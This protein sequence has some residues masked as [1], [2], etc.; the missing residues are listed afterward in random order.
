MNRSARDADAVPAHG[1]MFHHFRGGVHPPGQGAIT[2]DDLADIIDWIGE[3]RFLSAADWLERAMAGRLTPTDRCLT[4]DDGLRCQYD[5]ALPVLQ[6]YGLTAFWFTYTSVLDGVVERLELYR[7]FRSVNFPSV[8]AF[9]ETFFATLAASPLAVEVAGALADFRS[10][11]YLSQYVFYT[12][13]DRWFRFVRDMVLGPERYFAVMDTLVQA[14]GLD[15]GRL[16]DQL[17]MTDKQLRGLTEIGHV[18]GLHSHTHPTRMAGLPYNKQHR[19][20]ETN[21][22]RLTDTIGRRPTTASF[23]CGSYNADTLAVLEDLGVRMAF[24]AD[25]NVGGGSL[26]EL[27]R[28]D[29]ANVMRAMGRPV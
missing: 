7:Y 8:E 28:E 17:W 29:H 9:Y 18:V 24:R 6:A 11:T 19:E 12:E 27:P 13:G 21:S 10:G 23:P 15:T 20:F 25:M 16:L 1:V 2:S 22:R 14:A 4:F 3:S 5:L 26:L